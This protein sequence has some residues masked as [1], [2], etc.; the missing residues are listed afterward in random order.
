MNNSDSAVRL[1]DD[2]Q[3][4]ENS[5]I[6]VE[7]EELTVQT[8]LHYTVDGSRTKSDGRRRCGEIAVDQVGHSASFTVHQVKDL[9]R[10]DAE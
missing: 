2:R 1:N 8:N 5:P 4:V 3:R 9:T 7:T 6:E 10:V